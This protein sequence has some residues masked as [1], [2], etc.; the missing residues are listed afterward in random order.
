[1]PDRKKKRRAMPKIKDADVARILDEL[2]AWCRRERPGKL[3]WAVLEKLSGFSSQSL[4]A[5]SEIQ[6]RYDAAKAALRGN[7]RRIY[8]PKPIDQQV[9]ALREEVAMLKGII[10]R[11]DER[12]ARYALNAARLG[13]ELE[14]LDAPMDPPARAHVRVVRLGRRQTR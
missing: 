9:T 5:H 2:D 4:S 8:T 3:T 11:Y 7:E 6:R 10:Q 12:W 1:M 14:R 13:W